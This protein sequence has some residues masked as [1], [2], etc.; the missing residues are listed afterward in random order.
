MS[1]V[2]RRHEMFRR[3]KKRIVITIMALLTLILVGTVGFIYGTTYFEVYHSNQQIMEDFTEDNLQKG[4]LLPG[5]TEDILHG[6]EVKGLVDKQSVVL[7]GGIF[8]EDGD[9]EA[10]LNDLKP[11]MDDESLVLVLQKIMSLGKSDGIFENFIYR[12]TSSN[13]RIYIVIMDNTMMKDSMTSLV[14][15]TMIFGG[16]ALLVLFCI[17]RY[18]ADRIVRP[19]EEGYQRQKQFIS[20]AGHELKTPI[21]TISANSEILEREFG[22]NQWLSNIQFENHRMKELVQQL[23]ELARTENVTPI[24]EKMNLSRVVTGG[25]LPFESI[26][27]EKGYRLETEISDDIFLIGDAQQ[28]GQ[29]VSTLVDNALTHMNGE[30]NITVRLKK[31]RNT[32][33]FSVTNPGEE[34]PVGERDKIFERFY[35]TDESRTLSGHYGLGLAIAKAIVCAHN[36]RISV[37]CAHGFTT[38]QAVFLQK[39]KN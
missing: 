21:S 33:S 36:G 2:K 1:Y 27:F 14:K 24:F 23:L 13:G 15:N 32:I 9:I 29:L 7:Y 37:S 26:A 25:V 8:E 20:D 34:I 35:Q 5:S 30:G 39:N 6:D 10:V 28:M 16:I 3:S 18:L 12:V 17:S 19:L 22:G 4:I 31:E 38:F 11:L